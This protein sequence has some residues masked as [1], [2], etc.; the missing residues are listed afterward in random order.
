MTQQHIIFL[1]LAVLA[2]ALLRLL[3]GRS[4]IGRLPV[5]TRELMTKRERIVCG[6]IE[7][8]IPSARVHAQV[9][10]GAILQP[11]RGLDRSRATSVRNRFSSKRVDFL[12]EDRASGDIIAIVELDDRTHNAR[13]DAQRDQMT[14]RAGYT[15]IR[16]SGGRQTALSVRSALAEA[17]APQPDSRAMRRTAA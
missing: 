11:A 1:V 10:M 9:S 14:A 4:G 17:L 5:R 8:A 16:L 12:L 2:V 6:F 13:Q 15:T 3:G 7:Q